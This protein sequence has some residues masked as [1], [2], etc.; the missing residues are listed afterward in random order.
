[1]REIIQKAAE[2][3]FVSTLG[4]TCSVQSESVVS[5]VYVSKISL[6]NNGIKYLF[7]LCMDEALLLEVSKVMFMD[8]TPSQDTLIDLA[9]ESANLIVGNAKILLSSGD[10]ETI[11]LGTPE[12]QGY[13][14]YE[15]SKTFEERYFFDVENYIVC[16]GLETVAVDA[17]LPA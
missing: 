9:N 14:E 13:W 15:Y 1:M 5:G 6:I 8:E 3:F 12:Y 11:A 16:I 2:N 17:A 4:F 7:Y 10:L